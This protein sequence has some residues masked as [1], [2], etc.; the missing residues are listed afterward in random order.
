MH[1][2]FSASPS[3]IPNLP[4]VP[5]SAVSSNSFVFFN[6]PS[7]TF[8]GSF[9][10]SSTASQFFCPNYQAF[11][12]NRSLFSRVKTPR[13]CCP[14]R[15]AGT[16]YYSTLKVGRNATLQEIKSSYRKLARKVMVWWWCLFSAFVY[17]FGC[18][19]SE[20]KI[21]KLHGVIRINVLLCGKNWKWKRGKL[22][23]VFLRSLC[24]VR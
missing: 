3:T 10:L 6:L 8:T 15:A 17:L 11:S 14:I 21:R 5:I 23:N 2:L 24:W 1:S 16:D 12:P 9:G 13:T 20:G 18:W 7:S 19:E 4:P 22:G